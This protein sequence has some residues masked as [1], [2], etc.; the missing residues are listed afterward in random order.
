[1]ANDEPTKEQLEAEFSA[2]DKELCNAA[3]KIQA[4]FRGHQSRKEGGGSSSNAK[5][6]ELSK[7]M[8]KMAQEE[9][10]DIDLT[11][12]DLHK[13]ATKI[14]ASFRGHKKQK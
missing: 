13:A 2:D 1:M 7:D 6:E 4:S 5:V 12:P 8:Q 11:D 14:Q 3:T 10:L 9:E